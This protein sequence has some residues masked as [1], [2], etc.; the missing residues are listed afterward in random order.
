M[1]TPIYAVADG[2][3]SIAGSHTSY[4]DRT[5]QIKHLQEDG[6]SLI[7]H[8]THLSAVV[9]G[10]IEGL[11]VEKGEII[12]YSGQ[13]SSSYPHLH[14]EIRR[15]DNGS[16]YQR[17][18]IHPLALLPYE[19][20]SLPSLIV[21]SIE[22]SDNL[23]SISLSITVSRTELDLVGAELEIS[24]PAGVIMLRSI[25]FNEWNAAHQDTS[26]LDNPEL[27]GISISPDEY[28]DNL[29]QDWRLV[30]NVTDMSLADGQSLEA[31]F[32]AW[33]VLGGFSEAHFIIPAQ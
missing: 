15:S 3:I 17:N 11:E 18:A 1:G 8:Y 6:S 20:Q 29:G 7:S 26:T 10:L 28:N 27:Y 9:D 4:E 2:E 19:D 23:T 21:E 24:D 5:V 25:D 22:R 32:R 33:D 30:L 31:T 14:F 16:S 12:A 13:G